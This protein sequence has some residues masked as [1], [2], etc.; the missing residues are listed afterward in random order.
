MTQG[1]LRFVQSP[2]TNPGLLFL[3]SF[4]SILVVRVMLLPTLTI[5][6]EVWAEAGTNFYYHARYSSLWDNLWATD[7]GYLPWLQRIIAVAAVRIGFDGAAYPYAIQWAGQILSALSASLLVLPVFHRVIP[8]T[9]VRL[10]LALHVGLYPN[11]ELHTFIN[12]SYFGIF[13][14]TFVLLSAANPLST[15][16]AL[17]LTLGLLVVLPSKPY[18]LAF[19]PCFAFFSLLGWYKRSRPQLIVGV[20]GLLALLLQYGV[21]SLH[22]AQFGGISTRTLESITFLS[23][24][25]YYQCYSLL[26]AVVVDDHVALKDGGAATLNCGL[27]LTLGILVLLRLKSLWTQDRTALIFPAACLMVSSAAMALNL[28]AI[29]LF[30]GE[31]W[32]RLPRF[33]PKNRALFFSENALLLGVCALLTSHRSHS[34][35]MIGLLSSVIGYGVIIAATSELKDFYSSDHL[36]YSRWKTYHTMAKDDF[37][38]VPIN[39]FPWMIQKNCQYLSPALEF[40][41]PLSKAYERIVL[42]DLTGRAGEA[43]ILRALV[44]PP[45]TVNQGRGIRV[46]AFGADGQILARAVKLSR[47]QSDFPFFVFPDGVR[48]VHSIGLLREQ[49]PQEII[50]VAYQ[51][52]VIGTVITE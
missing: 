31:S 20:G 7:S 2:V 19:A 46:T 25:M 30:G 15:R 39:P 13:F 8:S 33:L 41:R 38:C 5:K 28:L 35:L 22:K 14:V 4:L 23:D 21:M 32:L 3:I 26:R 1:F 34:K 48:G 49:S 45:A 42:R 51:P 17:L 29:D 52:I 47:R 37:A 16:A 24:L 43:V 12:F 18:F 40:G 44:V 50:P 27:F 10:L 11:Y 36:A 6:P 9:L